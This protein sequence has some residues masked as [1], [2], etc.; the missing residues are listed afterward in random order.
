MKDL[1]LSIPQ[2]KQRVLI[3][4]NVLK[5]FSAARQLSRD[6]KETGG[7]L[8][9]EI[10]ADWI[11]IV[12]AS[13]ADAAAS[14]SRFRF[15]PKLKTRRERIIRAFGKGLHFVGEWHT[16]PEYDPSPS[17]LD[18]KS[19]NDSFIKSKHELTTFMMIIVGNRPNELSLRVTLH[20]GRDV[21]DLGLFRNPRPAKIRGEGSS[22]GSNR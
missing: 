4:S 10:S 22:K 13:N 20:D 5:T 16:H 7:L 12:D 3:A 1:T 6:A 17:V 19:M 21:I 18:N 14:V 2:S 8:F 9:A 11:N 15:V